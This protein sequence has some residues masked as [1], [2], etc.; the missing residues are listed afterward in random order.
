[1]WDDVADLFAAD[2]TMELGLQGVYAGKTSIRRALDQF[3]PQGLREGE[4]NDRLQLQ[5]IVHVAP[6]GRTA[7]ARGVELAMSGV[8]GVGGQWGEG[9][10]ENEFIKKNGVWQIKS[11]HFYPRLLTDYDKG[12]AK[13]AKP[14]PGP[15][16]DF[17][18][19]RPPTEVYE[20]FPKF[21]IPPFHF[22]NP[23][24]GL[25]TR[26]PEGTNHA[27]SPRQSQAGGR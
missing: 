22:A 1:M 26:Y 11:M 10:F 8:N 12:W 14:A 20:I 9:V 18:P 15:S 4:L 13:D 27:G 7:K 24:T 3:G 2:A 16:K 6:D 21:Y 19:D 17:P 25:A 5:T 23:V